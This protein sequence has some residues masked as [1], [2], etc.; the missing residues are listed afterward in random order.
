MYY[1][2]SRHEAG[3]AHLRHLD[4][5][6]QIRLGPHTG[7]VDA[8]DVNFG[9]TREQIDEAMHER[10]NQAALRHRIKAQREEER[11]V[12]ENTALLQHLMQSADDVRR[13]AP[14]KCHHFPDDAEQALRDNVH[15]QLFFR[16]RAARRAQARLIGKDNEAILMHLINVR[17]GVRTAKSLDDWYHRTHKKRLAQLSRFRRDEPFAGAEILRNECGVHLYPRAPRTNTRTPL[18][19]RQPY[20]QPPLGELMAT[21]PTALLPVLQTTTYGG[22]PIGVSARA[23]PDRQPPPRRRE[24]QSIAATDIPLMHYAADKA[25]ARV[26]NLRKVRPSEEGSCTKLW[27]RAARR[28]REGSERR[29]EQELPGSCPRRASMAGGLVTTTENTNSISG[30]S[31]RKSQRVA[32]STSRPPSKA[33]DDTL[34][35]PTVADG[36]VQPTPAVA[37]APQPPR[38]F[39]LRRH[40]GRSKASTDDAADSC[41]ANPTIP[42]TDELTRNQVACFVQSLADRQQQQ[43]QTQTSVPFRETVVP[44]HPPSTHRGSEPRWSSKPPPHRALLTSSTRRASRRVGSEEVPSSAFSVPQQLADLSTSA[45]VALAVSGA[46]RGAWD[47]ALEQT[48]THPY[49]QL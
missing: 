25:L 12:R 26:S 11:L 23:T 7:I 48:G 43:Y 5:L 17:P 30:E 1:A 21:A 35:P 13:G 39:V 31:H 47:G 19:A 44:Q 33:F 15:K 36:S 37:I 14:K 42:V 32:N 3:L 38:S 4:R 8:P 29:K 20:P 18:I 10:A 9:E 41:D 22:Y 2:R 24:W 27:R 28:Q 16:N 6:A 45:P 46:I 34:P 49:L 40:T